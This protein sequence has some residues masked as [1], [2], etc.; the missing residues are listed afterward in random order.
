VNPIDQEL[1]DLH[2]WK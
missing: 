1:L 2:P